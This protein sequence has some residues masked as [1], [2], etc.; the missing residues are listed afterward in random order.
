V[1]NVTRFQLPNVSI[2]DYVFGVAAVNADGHESLISAYVSANRRMQEVQ[3]K[4]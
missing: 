3:V 4:K 1:G 2:D